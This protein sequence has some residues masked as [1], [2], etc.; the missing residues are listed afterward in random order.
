MLC[1]H[2]VDDSYCPRKDEEDGSLEGSREGVKEPADGGSWRWIV[3]C[4]LWIVDCGLWTVEV[5]WKRKRKLK[6]SRGLAAM[7]AG[8]EKLEA[9]SNREGIPERVENV[10]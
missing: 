9:G 1:H 4:G 10:D 5:K 6:G 8:L 3:D 2:S 7:H